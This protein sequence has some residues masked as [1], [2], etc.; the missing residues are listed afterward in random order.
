V[1]ANRPLLE[2]AAL[3]FTAAFFFEDFRL[4][5]VISSGVP[6]ERVGLAQCLPFSSDPVEVSDW[7][8]GMVSAAGLNFPFQAL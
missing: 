3:F 5:A 4:R 7:E 8:A 2:T 6:D 1:I